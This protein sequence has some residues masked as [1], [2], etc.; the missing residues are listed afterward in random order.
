MHISNPCRVARRPWPSKT[1]TFLA[2]LRHDRIVAPFVL[3]G[4]INGTAFIA[5]VGQCLDH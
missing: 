4:L 1:L 5:W 2:R 3:E